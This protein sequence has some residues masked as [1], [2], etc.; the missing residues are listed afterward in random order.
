MIMLS[1]L[2][3]SAAVLTISWS[4]VSLVARQSHTP[5]SAMSQMLSVGTS[6]DGKR[7]A[8]PPLFVSSKDNLDGSENAYKLLFPWG[9]FMIVCVDL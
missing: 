1:T 6:L 8:I 4:A 7:D 2:R 5:A 3:I 9:L